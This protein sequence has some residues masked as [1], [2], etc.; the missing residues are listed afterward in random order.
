MFAEALY[1]DT[2]R[3]DAAADAR[4][5]PL[6]HV[7]GRRRRSCS[8]RGWPFLAGCRA[9]IARSALPGMDTLIASSMLLAYLVASLFETLRGGPQV[10]YDAAVMF[11]FLLLRRAHARATRA[12]IAQRTGRCAG[13]RATG[14]GHA[15]TRRRRRESSRCTH[16]RS[17]TSCA[18]R[19]G[20]C[21]PADGVLLDAPARFEEV[22][23]HGRVRPGRQGRARRCSPV[24]VCRDRPR[25]C[26]S[27]RSAAARA[28]RS[29]RALVE[30]AQ[31]HRPRACAAR[32]SRRP[33]FVMALL[34]VA[35]ATLCSSWHQVRARSRVRSRRW[36]C[37]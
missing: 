21:V 20:K 35:G 12:R 9:R 15:R 19:P 37:W 30:R 18:W 6:G 5:L 24:R 17:A 23:A 7:P 10:W 16:W 14:A 34:L 27:P 32:R 26:A 36:H 25:A 31:A 13:A 8:T 29:S 2:A 4:L 28:C 22:V 33:H 11:V 1:L 3:R